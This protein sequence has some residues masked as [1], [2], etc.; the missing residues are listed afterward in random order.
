MDIKRELAEFIREHFA[1]GNDSEFTDDVNLFDYG[2]VDSLGAIEIIDFIEDQWKI[3]ITQRDL[4]LY[5]MNSIE[6][7]T[8][9][10]EGKL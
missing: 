2:F 7:M 1:I 3:E 9:V 4:T 6:E 8:E 10:I 5:P